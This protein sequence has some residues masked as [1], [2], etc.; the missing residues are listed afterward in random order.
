MKLIGNS[1]A[2]CVGTNPHSVSAYRYRIKLDERCIFLLT[3]IWGGS[4]AVVALLTKGRVL[5]TILNAEQGVA[6][7]GSGSHP[8]P[9]E[10]RKAA[11][12]GTTT[13]MRGAR[14]NRSGRKSG[15]GSAAPE[16]KTATVRAPGGGRPASW[17]ARRL[18]RRL[19]CRVTCRPNGC[20]ASTRRLSALRH[21]VNSGE[22]SQNAKP[23]RKKRAAGTRRCC[24]VLT[25]S[26]AHS[27]RAA[28]QR[29]PE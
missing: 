19:A 3:T 12:P 15:E 29:G 18:V 8:L 24:L 6:S 22:R 21:P 28:I 9:R 26:A 4:N 5:E 20:L 17:D 11:Q 23:G 14:C 16:P 25:L 27:G 1:L 10:V 7:C 2:R 13:R